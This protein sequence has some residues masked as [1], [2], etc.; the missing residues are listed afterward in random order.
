MEVGEAD[1]SSGRDDAR[2][3]W[4]CSCAFFDG[5]CRSYGIDMRKVKS[6]SLLTL[7]LK[8][9]TLYLLHMCYIGMLVASHPDSD[10]SFST[11]LMFYLPSLWLFKPLYGLLDD[12]MDWLLRRMAE[13]CRRLNGEV[14]TSMPPPGRKRSVMDTLVDLNKHANVLLILSHVGIITLLPSVMIYSYIHPLSAGCGPYM[15]VLLSLCQIASGAVSDGAFCRYVQC[16]NEL[17]EVQFASLRLLFMTGYGLWNMLSVFLPYPRSIDIVNSLMTLV[18]L[19]PCFLLGNSICVLWVL[20]CDPGSYE[21]AVDMSRRAKT[22]Y[23]PKVALAFLALMYLAMSVRYPYDSVLVSVSRLRLIPVLFLL[24]LSIV[25][26]ILVSAV[27]LRYGSLEKM[28]TIA[29]YL[30]VSCIVVY[31][32]GHKILPIPNE[33]S[34]LW[35]ICFVAALNTAVHQLI[36]TFGIVLSIRSAPKGWE[37]SVMSLGDLSFDVVTYMY[38]GR[39]SPRKLALRILPSNLVVDILAVFF[40][41][42]SVFTIF[43]KTQMA[44]LMHRG[45]LDVISPT[46]TTLPLPIQVG[47]YASS[48]NGV[49]S[50]GVHEDGASSVLNAHKALK[51][52]HVDKSP[53]AAESEFSDGSD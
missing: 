15:I 47:E 9:E 10:K 48:V 29:K 36:M 19:V 23:S 40:C 17:S 43:G 37:A 21:E 16:N 7:L 45:T 53:W 49:A 34:S 18:N 22:S 3:L 24:S 12:C 27:L 5:L 44:N 52:R 6:Y 8:S 2:R 38:R 13:G 28:L 46:S 51:S 42:Y 4:P 14:D 41:L 30:F 1:S 20:L 11:K 50:A 25:V 32:G 39:F 31:C 33:D 26:K 35:Y